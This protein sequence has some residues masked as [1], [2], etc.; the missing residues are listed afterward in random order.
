MSKTEVNQTAHCRGQN[1][2]ADAA[3]RYKPVPA[4]LLWGRPRIQ[5]HRGIGDEDQG[6]KDVRAQPV[7]HPPILAQVAA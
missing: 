4:P 2:E 3:H 5:T 7:P 1:D 6:K